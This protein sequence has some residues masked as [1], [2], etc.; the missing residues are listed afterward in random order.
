MA[1]AD[2][3]EQFF[4]VAP[5]IFELGRRR[6]NGDARGRAASDIDELIEDFRVI[7]FLLGAANRH[8]AAA[9]GVV[10]VIG[11]SHCCSYSTV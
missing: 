9:P 2:L 11:R 1:D 3:A 5:G 6:Y 8:Q 7:E 4:V 10:S